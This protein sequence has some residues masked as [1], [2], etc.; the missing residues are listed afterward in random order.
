MYSTRCQQRGS[1]WERVTTQEACLTADECGDEC[2][3]VLWWT[4]TAEE[5][6]PLSPEAFHIGSVHIM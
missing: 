2:S 4:R 1:L 6:A 3:A 5:E